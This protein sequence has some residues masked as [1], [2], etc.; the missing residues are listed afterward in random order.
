M[1][2]INK[3]YTKNLTEDYN[4]FSFNNVLHP[5]MQILFAG[6]KDPEKKSVMSFFD[7]E[8]LKKIISC[9]PDLF[10]KT[11]EE[12]FQNFPAIAER[13]C[14]SYLLKNSN[15][16]SDAIN[17]DIIS[18]AGQTIFDAAVTKT[19][20]ELYNLKNAY[21]KKLYLTEN[22][23]DRLK[24]NI[25]RSK[26]RRYLCRL[27]NAKRGKSVTTNFDKKLFP[28]WI[29]NL[30]TCFDY[31]TIASKFGNL[32]IEQLSLT[33]CP[34]CALESIQNYSSIK[35]RPDL[36]HFYPRSRFPFLA[37]SLYNLIPAG[38]ICNQKLKKNHTML[39]HMHPYIDS[40][41]RDKV[42]RVG[43]IPDGNIGD[44]LSIDIIPQP[45]AS[46]DKNISLFKIKEIYNDN[47]D[48]KAWYSTTYD[49]SEYLRTM[50]LNLAKINF[51]SP[52][53]KSVIDLERPITKVYAQK[54]KVESINDLFKQE[55]DIV[56]QPAE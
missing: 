8:R 33:V 27:E 20:S 1:I 16:V 48:L 29:N 42:F 52:L 14:Y 18:P 37:I 22:I 28:D 5:K 55:L 54:F 56:S 36:D 17:L 45:S 7:N 4:E 10:E 26:K 31:D 49:L 35:I 46:K 2:K 32:I 43:F 21:N 34:Y 11:I 24:S 3:K 12:I 53:Y 51:D 38:S 47:E 39:G 44:S 50:G 6:M 9:P 13:Y 40:L 15:I 25:P 41:E 23:I 19:I 30:E